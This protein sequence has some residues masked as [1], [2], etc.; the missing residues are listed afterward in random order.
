MGLSQVLYIYVKV[1]QLGVL[2]VHCCSPNSESGD[3][4]D[5][6]AYSWDRF[7]PTGLPNSA[8]I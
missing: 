4:S 3:V 2:V 6:F 1:V 5:C 7:V 8:M